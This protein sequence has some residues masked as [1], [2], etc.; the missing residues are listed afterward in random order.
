MKR[1]VLFPG[2]A[3]CG[4][5]WIA[6][7][8]GRHP[9]AVLFDEP[10]LARRG[11]NDHIT[12]DHLRIF[13]DAVYEDRSKNK[14]YIID[15]SPGAISTYRLYREVYENAYCLITYRDGKYFIF[16][17]LNM[18]WQSAITPEKY[19]STWIAGM[20]WIAELEPAHPKNMVVCYEDLLNDPT[21]SRE[22]TSFLRMEHH[23]DIEVWKEPARSIHSSYDPDRWKSLDKEILKD[24]ERMNPLLERF[25]YDPV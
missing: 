11:L 21:K 20:K 6:K 15:K 5:T 22:I 18:P 10:F 1:H 13:W 24:M 8:L 16:S 14:K 19:I 4:S 17:C 12:V 23:G 9:E 2:M 25:G 3:R 7:W